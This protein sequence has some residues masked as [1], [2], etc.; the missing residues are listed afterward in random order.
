MAARLAVPLALP[1][2][3]GPREGTVAM[4]SVDGVG[5]GMICLASGNQIV[6]VMEAHVHASNVVI[7]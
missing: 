4:Y 6:L 2:V 5:L 1:F 7:R 3:S